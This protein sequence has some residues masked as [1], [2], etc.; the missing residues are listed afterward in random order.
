MTKLIFAGKFIAKLLPRYRKCK[1]ITKIFACGELNLLDFEQVNVVAP[2][3]IW[4]NRN[5]SD[6]N[7]KI[8]YLR[9]DD[10]SIE[11]S[12][13]SDWMSHKNRFSLQNLKFVAWTKCD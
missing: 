10:I 8:H 5:E 4:R 9:L 7:S 3:K 2:I 1:K 6:S 13:S 12:P 11:A